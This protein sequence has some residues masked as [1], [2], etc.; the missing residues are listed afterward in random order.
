VVDWALSGTLVFTDPLLLDAE[1]PAT[2]VPPG[3]DHDW[4]LTVTPLGKL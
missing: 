2:I 3:A 4:L 1:Y